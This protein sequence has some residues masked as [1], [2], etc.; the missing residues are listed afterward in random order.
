MRFN[1]S[2]YLATA[3]VLSVGTQAASTA[4]A[5]TPDLS[6]PKTPKSAQDASSKWIW[7]F[8]YSSNKQAVNAALDDSVLLHEGSILEDATKASPFSGVISTTY[9]TLL[10]IMGQLAK[11]AQLQLAEHNEERHP[12]KC[13]TAPSS[14]S[15]EH[16]DWMCDFEHKHRRI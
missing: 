12:T 1:P 4:P 16:P 11:P 8:R 3:V 10:T 6:A 7:P 2:Q 14:S 5:P 9:T 15:G 13:V